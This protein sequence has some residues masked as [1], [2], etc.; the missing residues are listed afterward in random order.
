MTPHVDAEAYVWQYSEDAWRVLI[1]HEDRVTAWKTFP[2]KEAALNSFI[3]LR[4]G[5]TV[6]APE[7]PVQLASLN[8]TYDALD[9]YGTTESLS[10]AVLDLV[11]DYAP[12]LVGLAV[13]DVERE[14]GVL[15][16]KIGLVLSAFGLRLAWE[17]SDLSLGEFLKE[18]A[19]ILTSQAAAMLTDYST[20]YDSLPAK[21]ARLRLLAE[22]FQQHERRIGK[23]GRR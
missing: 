15:F 18:N 9:K 10:H 17:D 13:E 8:R 19:K 6:T 23:R 22:A 3:G 2:D 11:L 7:D 5:V 12:S 14:R 16:A 20:R 21:Q 4:R 1:E